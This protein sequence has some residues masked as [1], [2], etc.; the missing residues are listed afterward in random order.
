[1]SRAMIQPYGCPLSHLAPRSPSVLNQVACAAVSPLPAGAGLICTAAA[2]YH[3]Q[4]TFSTA[5]ICIAGWR[6]IMYIIENTEKPEVP[7]EIN[8]EERIDGS[9]HERK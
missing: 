3:E 1:M 4:L 7:E 9:V 2:S 6:R 8:H 5:G